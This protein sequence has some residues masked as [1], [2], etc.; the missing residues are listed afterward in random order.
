MGYRHT[1]EEILEAA[2]A[3]AVED[4]FAS[5]TFGAVGKRLGVADRTVVYY[6]PTK[7]ELAVAVVQQLGANLEALL[8]AAF[9]T[10]P[11]TPADLVRRAWPVLASE[12][13]DRVFALFFEVIGLAAA[14]Q[15]PYDTLARAVVRRW[16]EWLSAHILGDDELE[17]RQTA[18]AAVAQIDGLLLLRHLL[19]P[20]AA[21]SAA[22]AA[23]VAVGAPDAP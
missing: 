11:R 17:R 15:T 4:G 16:V 12:A 13:N 10:E 22:L 9:G 19:G 18:L 6:F 23:G 3:V 7:P 5:L 20:E 2:T 21:Q 8:E 14:R 1:R